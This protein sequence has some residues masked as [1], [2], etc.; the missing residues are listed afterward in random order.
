MIVRE[1]VLSFNSDPSQTWY[2]DITSRPVENARRNKFLFPGSQPD[3]INQNTSRKTLERTKVILQ[4]NITYQSARVLS[5]LFSSSKLIFKWR[6]VSS[7][8]QS[9]FVCCPDGGVSEIPSSF[10]QI[11]KNLQLPTGYKIKWETVP[12]IHSNIAFDLQSSKL[13]V[14]CQDYIICI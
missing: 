1:Q 5:H 6:T 8:L 9:S 2:S 3:Y 14:I 4:N 13:W 11:V 7:P 12:W 10:C